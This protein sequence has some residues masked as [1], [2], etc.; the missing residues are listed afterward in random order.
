MNEKV[1]EAFENRMTHRKIFL[2]GLHLHNKSVK[3]Q[4]IVM[5]S[6]RSTEHNIRSKSFTFSHQTA[7]T[8]HT[9]PAHFENGESCDG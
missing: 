1:C 8:A 9:M 3:V 5:A 4:Y 2:S 6:F 7:L